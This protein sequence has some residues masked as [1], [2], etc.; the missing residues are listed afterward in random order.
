[1]LNIDEFISDGPPTRS[2]SRVRMRTSHGI[3]KWFSVVVRKARWLRTRGRV[4]M[5][6][7]RGEMALHK[8]DPMK[9]QE[10]G[11]ACTWSEAR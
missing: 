9:D 2:H 4:R 8:R 7:E 6:V 11:S 1:M 5:H 3:K 10:A